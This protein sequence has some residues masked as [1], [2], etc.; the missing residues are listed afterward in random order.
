MFDSNSVEKKQT[1]NTR[2]SWLARISKEV[3]TSSDG[4]HCTVTEM[5]RFVRYI[6]G[7]NITESQTLRPR[8]TQGYNGGTEQAGYH[9]NDFVVP[10]V[11]RYLL[12]M[13]C[14]S[15]QLLEEQKPQQIIYTLN[16]S[17]PVF[18]SLTL[19]FASGGGLLHLHLPPHICL[20]RLRKAS[21]SIYVTTINQ[22]EDE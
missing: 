15:L 11:M 7:L 21:T 16:H 12:L 4:G 14:T 1:W 5:P 19:L 10:S 17:L 18:I 3:V 20:H 8:C 9:H 22:S 13:R 2:K 6:D